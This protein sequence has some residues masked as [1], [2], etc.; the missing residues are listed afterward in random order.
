ME[1]E[2]LWRD[3]TSD[4]TRPFG[5][6]GACLTAPLALRRPGCAYPAECAEI[7]DCVLRRAFRS[8]GGPSIPDPLPA[9]MHYD[10]KTGAWIGGPP[11]NATQSTTA[12]IRRKMKD[13]GFA[14]LDEPEE[15][16]EEWIDRK[17]EEWLARHKSP[18]GPLALD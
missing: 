4:L 9:T 8:H 1:R 18:G 14:P 12:R 10:R 6:K 11:E 7:G 17:R 2:R 13:Q 5:V 15:S 16:P 3:S